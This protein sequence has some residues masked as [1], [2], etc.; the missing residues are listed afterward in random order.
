MVPSL[1]MVKQ[2]LEKLTLF[3][4]LETTM[5]LTHQNRAEILMS[6]WMMEKCKSTSSAYK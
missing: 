2:A 4:V 6:P 5:N 1:P 3:K